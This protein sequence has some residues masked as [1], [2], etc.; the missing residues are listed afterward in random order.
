MLKVRNGYWTLNGKKYKEFNAT[1]M[2]IFNIL[3]EQI[4]TRNCVA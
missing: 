3:F 2:L 1:E 4:K